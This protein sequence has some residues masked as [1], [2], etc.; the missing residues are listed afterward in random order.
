MLMSMN[1]YRYTNTLVDRYRVKCDE[2]SPLT[3][4][5]TC[6]NTRVVSALLCPIC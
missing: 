3:P 6:S 5:S 2:K 1:V 4:C